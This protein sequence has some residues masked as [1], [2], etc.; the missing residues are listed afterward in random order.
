MSPAESLNLALNRLKQKL[1]TL[2]PE[3]LLKAQELISQV[4]ELREN[5]SIRFFKPNQAQFNYI[6]SVGDPLGFIVIFSA[7]NG[8]GKTAATVAL[9]AA[10]IWPEIA[11]KDVFG[12]FIY[13][14]WK[15]PRDFRIISTPQ[16]LG[17]GGSIQREIAKWFPKGQYSANKNG[18]NYLS[19]YR[20]KDFT[21]NLMSYDMAP[22][23]FEGSTNG[24]VAFNEP[25]PRAI[26]NA[27]AAR[28]RKGGR[29]ILPMTPLMDA[30]WIMDTLVSKASDTKYIQLVSGDIEDNCIEH[31]KH[32]ILK[33]EDIERMIKNYDPDE[34]EARRSGKFMH[35]SGTIL[36]T[37]DRN[38]HVAKE[39]IDPNQSDVTHTVVC[40]PAI[41]KPCAFLW[42]YVD[43]TKTV[44][45][46]D[47]YPN[48]EFQGAKDDNL[49]V[50]DYANIIRKKNE[51][52]IVSNYILDRHFGNTRRT[53]G[54]ST[55][56]QE[57]D[58]AGI[59][60]QD[61]YSMATDVEVETGILKIKDYLKYDKTKPMDALNR[62]KLII[63]PVCHN[64]ITAM[65]R[66]SRNPKTM[67]PKE[68]YK[69]FADLVR[70]LVMSDPEVDRPINMSTPKMAHYGVNN[71]A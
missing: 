46:Y 2:S 5:E 47:E 40:D 61:S 42:A 9:I 54:G 3:K 59:E 16:E 32:G 35:L 20:A 45:I 53:L 34:L 12:S 50:A 56:K 52:R 33:H 31:S 21:V 6:Q 39:P 68:E 17:E 51:G 27:C 49:T 13:Q 48:F 15:F 25:P 22:E 55:L 65:E 44:H 7:G 10:I 36:K 69:D 30:A 62:P 26:F 67:D 57:F 63:S 60:F 43:K 64:T 66:W 1:S 8:I 29:L 23:A 28:M 11:P 24:L 71:N 38:I 70:Y 14:N 18:K 19:R 58:T 4:R 37:F 41:G